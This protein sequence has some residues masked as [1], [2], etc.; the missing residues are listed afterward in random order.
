MAETVPFIH[1]IDAAMHFRGSVRATSRSAIQGMV[2]GVFGQ[3]AGDVLGAKAEVATS[4]G[5]SDTQQGTKYD[6]KKK[7][8]GE[9]VV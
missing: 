5:A 6:S 4:V 9:T 3:A 2:K 7:E 8:R 1:E